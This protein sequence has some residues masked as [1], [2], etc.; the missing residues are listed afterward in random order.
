VSAPDTTGCTLL[1]V[2]DEDAN[3]DLLEAVLTREGY[4]SL[5]RTPDARR[6]VPLWEEVRPDLVLLDLHMPH[7]SGFEVLEELRARTPADD[8]LPVL[9]LTADA[10]FAAKQRALGEG[11][12]DFVT[13]PFNN[14]EVV[15]RVRNL[16]RTRIL[17]REQRRA[18]EAAELLAA[19]SRALGASF[20]TDTALEQ[21][22]R[23]LV[24][25]LA[26]RCAVDLFHEPGP[27]R[28]AYAR[29]DPGAGVVLASDPA[30]PPAAGGGGGA[31]RVLRAPADAGELRALFG[32]G[33]PGAA[34]V[35]PLAAGGAPVGRLAL[36][37][38]DA[39]RPVH[40]GDLTLA[41]EVAHRAALA[42]ENARLFREARA[43]T[44]ARERILAVVAHDLRSPLC[45]IRFDAEML[46][47]RL[48]AHG[49]EGEARM[50]ARVDQAA[51]RMDGLIEDLLDVA[52]MDGGVLAL[53]PAE[54]DA[55]A[56]LADAAEM[57][58]PLAAAHGLAFRWEPAGDAPPLHADGARLVQVV[59]NLV[60]NAV[61]FT[62]A[63][64]TVTLA[65]RAEGDG[66]RVSVADTGPGI[67]PEQVPHVFGAFW[68]AR[69]ADRRGLGLGLVIARGI[70]EAHGGRIWVESEPGRG[71]TFVFTLPAAP[72]SAAPGA[73]AHSHPEPAAV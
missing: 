60:G 30:A 50:A 28:A 56:L 53:S 38:A 31:P 20:D 16:L 13:K 46:H 48:R 41:A 19:A 51:A 67:P 29:L 45:A 49:S 59:S 5:V 65:C 58:R 24:P 61:K 55:D 52:R 12:Q 27:R 8:F 34:V 47:E 9:V 70:V 14:A 69:N 57:L 17:H 11:A 33:A 42:V 22:A 62:P 73:P 64:G 21:L 23:L 66:I 7:R 25:R 2:D 15:L 6:A 1:L 63:G 43:A 44:E 35:A 4:H 3:L 18:R 54:T 10:T 40:A 36:G 32:G 39:G 68:Q 71:T 37:W 72:P 26:E